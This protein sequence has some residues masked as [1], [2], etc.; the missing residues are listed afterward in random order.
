[1]TDDTILT[2]PTICGR[3][4][5]ELA[6][7]QMRQH[8][9][10]RIERCAWKWAA[11]YTLVRHGRIVPQALSP[12]ERAHRRGIAFP[13]ETIERCLPIGMPGLQTFQQVL[14][15]LTQLALPPTHPCQDRGR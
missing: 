9:A 12:R 3:A 4:E 8:R 13:A 11:Y 7:Q 1:M 15:G 5:V 14:D 10:C 6:H 2:P